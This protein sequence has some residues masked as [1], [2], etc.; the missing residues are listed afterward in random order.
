MSRMRCAARPVCQRW[1]PRLEQLAREI[2]G[3]KPEG[4]D[5]LSYRFDEVS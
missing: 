1:Q 4:G 5:W 3:A 2:L